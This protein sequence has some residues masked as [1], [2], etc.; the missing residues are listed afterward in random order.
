MDYFEI[1]TKHLVLKPLGKQYLKSTISY[2]MDYENTKYMCHL[3]DETV[4]EAEEFLTNVEA[5]WK[6]KKPKFLE[7][8]IIYHDIH[9][10]A[11]SVYFENDTGELGWIIN[12]NYWGNGFA[13]EAA[14]ALIDYVKTEIKVNRFLAHCDTE[15]A[16]SY[17]VME[18]LGMSRT[19]EWGGRRNRS[20]TE[21][22]LEYQYELCL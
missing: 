2:A 11:V 16:A 12:K 18:K 13:Y 21:D 14:K 22:S 5:E 17:K 9:I 8:A 15:N 1:H 4:E 20:A 19:G 3:P 7:F 10:G 6:K